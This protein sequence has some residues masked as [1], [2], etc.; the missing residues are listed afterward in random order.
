L[1]FEAAVRRNGAGSWVKGEYSQAR[2]NHWR[3][4]LEANWIR[5]RTDDFLGQYRRNSNLN[6]AL[7]Y[8]F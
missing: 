5:G 2:G 7:R 4:T 1:T 8:S 3:T 6:L